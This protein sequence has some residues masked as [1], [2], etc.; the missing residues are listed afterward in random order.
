MRPAMFPQ[1]ARSF[2]D[3]GAGVWVNPHLDTIIEDGVRRTARSG[4]TVISQDAA[5]P[6]SEGVR[7]VR[8]A[9]VP[10]SDV[11]LDLLR[12]AGVGG[13][14]VPPPPTGNLPGLFSE[15]REDLSRMGS[16]S[17]EIVNIAEGAV[18][19]GV[20]LPVSPTSTLSA[21]AGLAFLPLSGNM[22]LQAA[23]VGVVSMLVEKILE[24]RRRGGKVEDLQEQSDKL[25]SLLTTVNESIG[26]ITPNVVV[27]RQVI[28]SFKNFSNYVFD[29]L[30]AGT[31]EQIKQRAIDYAR[32]QLSVG[33][34]AR[35]MGLT[36][37]MNGALNTKIPTYEQRRLQR[38]TTGTGKYLTRVPVSRAT[39]G[40]KNVRT[41]GNII[42]KVN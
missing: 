18:G 15:M 40:S 10:T 7:A 12:A 19:A 36:D 6:I 23:G 5:G 9:F 14:G 11:P 42:D 2:E 21:I 41:T 33:S 4:I 25:A 29:T 38:L 16:M 32:R 13:G 20:P 3:I 8:S 35:S 39:S 27:D 31:P 22:M 34:L 30:G 17:N 28:K 26:M 24:Y 1:S 37:W